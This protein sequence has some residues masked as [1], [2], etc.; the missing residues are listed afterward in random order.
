MTRDPETGRWIFPPTTITADVLA[1][2]IR[3]GPQ[4]AGPGRELERLLADAMAEVQNVMAEA[5]KAADSAFL[6]RC[7]LEVGRELYKRTDEPSGSSQFADFSTGQPVR[8]PRDPLQ[9]L[10]PD[11]RRYVLPL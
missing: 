11:L 7:Y 1:D 10:W 8:G 5:F 6:D 2:F 4:G 3:V 9:Q